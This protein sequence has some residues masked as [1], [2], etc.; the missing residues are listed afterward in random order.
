MK[1][2]RVGFV[3]VEIRV[4]RAIRVPVRGNSASCASMLNQH[5][6]T[7]TNKTPPYKNINPS[8][9]PAPN[10]TVPPSSCTRE[11]KARIPCEVPRKPQYWTQANLKAP[12]YD[13]A[14]RS[15]IEATKSPVSTPLCQQFS[16][17]RHHWLQ[18]L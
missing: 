16:Q 6:S 7:H 14:F 5:N 18:Y 4:I 3:S 8:P 1:R 11:R 2:M 9:P 17:N 13:A 12:R 15:Q 10:P